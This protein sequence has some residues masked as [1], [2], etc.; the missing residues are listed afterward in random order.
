MSTQTAATRLTANDIAKKFYDQGYA[1]RLLSR[2]QVDWIAGVDAREREQAG[3]AVSSRHIYGSIYAPGGVY[4]GSWH[5]NIQRNGCAVFKFERWDEEAEAEKIRVV[6]GQRAASR[7]R[8]YFADC[9]DAVKY[10]GQIRP[11]DHA[12]AESLLQARQSLFEFCLETVK[13]YS[14]AELNATNADGIVDAIETLW[15]DL[16]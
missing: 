13:R 1:D 9:L 7:A 2:K 4:L 10:E 8:Q 16:N 3:V 11:E 5:L 14:W 15:F 6:V 12:W